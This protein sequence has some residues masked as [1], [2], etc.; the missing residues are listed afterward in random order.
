MSRLSDF[1]VSVYGMSQPDRTF[2]QNY[3]LEIMSASW[4]RGVSDEAHAFGCPYAFGKPPSG[5]DLEALTTIANSDTDSIVSTFNRD[6][7]RYVEKLVSANPTQTDWRFF[8][9]QIE[10][11]IAARNAW[12]NQQIA[13]NA[14]TRAREMGRQRFWQMNRVQGKF[15]AYPLTSVCPICVFIISAGTV[16]QAFVDEHPLPAHINCTHE[17][18]VVNATPRTI[19]CDLMWLG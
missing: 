18:R 5:S 7:A 12:K 13:L 3:L 9:G 19:P 2:F 14:E 10:A 11:W 17:Y 4:R 16:D 15:K 1:L 8:S 6:L